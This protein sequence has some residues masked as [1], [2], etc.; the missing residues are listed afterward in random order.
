MEDTGAIGHWKPG[1]MMPV[2]YDQARCCRELI[3]KK[4]IFDRLAKGFRPGDKFELPRIE[5]PEMPPQEP[6]NE[7]NAEKI[8][9]IATPVRKTVSAMESIL[10]A[11]PLGKAYSVLLNTKS[12]VLHRMDDEGQTTVCPYVRSIAAPH[13]LMQQGVPAEYKEYDQCPKCWWA[14][15]KKIL[16][17]VEWD[18]PDDGEVSEASSSS[19]TTTEGDLTDGADSEP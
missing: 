5:E 16:E 1:S 11:A 13:Y 8:L 15:A 2:K 14:P 6:Q 17:D 19:G 12:K 7:T 10:T 18:I 4:D 9:K 3:V